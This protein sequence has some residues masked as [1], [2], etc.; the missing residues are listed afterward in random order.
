MPIAGGLIE[1]PAGAGWL[2]LAGSSDWG[3]GEARW[4]DLAALSVADLG[5]QVVFVPTA[6][7]MDGAEF[8]AYYEDLGALPGVVAPIFTAEDAARPEVRRLLARSGLIYLGDGDSRR[9][10]EA[11]AGSQALEGM[12]EAYRRGAVIVG[13]G[14]GAV[15]LAAWGRAADGALLAGWGWLRQAVIEPHFEGEVSAAR[16]REM[17]RRTQARYGLGIPKRTALALAPDGA[18]ETWGAGQVTV[19]LVQRQGSR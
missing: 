16:L 17:V 2:V 11:L 14:A 12:A 10:I 19:S 7:C 4:I 9:L 3:Q 15:A 6:G 5:R 13:A 1:W 18:V 8:L